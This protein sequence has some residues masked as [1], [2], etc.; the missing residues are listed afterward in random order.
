M[1]EHTHDFAA[2]DR[3]VA[4]ARP[5]FPAGTVMKLMTQ[6]YVLVRWDGNVLE[7]TYHCE[8]DKAD[9]AGI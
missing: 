3:V 4:P 9:L 8:L 2:G 5:G 7:T 6:G 1:D